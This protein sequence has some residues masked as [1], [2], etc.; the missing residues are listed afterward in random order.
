MDTKKQ[1]YLRMTVVET[2]ALVAALPPGL[3]PPTC[4]TAVPVAATRVPSLPTAISEY[5]HDTRYTAQT[6]KQMFILIV[7]CT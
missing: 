4:T 1:S 3:N 7:S 5:L 6:S 2:I